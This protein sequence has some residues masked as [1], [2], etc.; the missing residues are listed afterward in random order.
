VIPCEERGLFLGILRI[1]LTLIGYSFLQIS[2]KILGSEPDFFRFF[3]VLLLIVGASF[4]FPYFLSRAKIPEI[5]IEKT[6]GKI[7][8]LSDFTNILRNI[9]HR[10]YFKFLA[11]WTFITGI[12][13][14]FLIPFYS[15][16]LG[17]SSSF[18]VK[19]VSANTLGYGFAAFV[20]GKIVD[21]RGSR[22]VLFISCSLAV[23]HMFFLAHIHL[24]SIQWMK[25]LLIMLSFLGG[26]AFSG[27]LMGDTTRRMTL[28][29]EKNKLSYFAYVQVFGAQIPLVI[30]SPLAGYLIQRN[31]GFHAGIYG[32]YQTVMIIAGLFYLVLLHTIIRMRPLKEKPILELLKDSM[33]EGLMKIRD[34]IASPP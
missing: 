5:K 31:R 13:G 34:I 15:T 20:W 9:D 7:G 3:C 21:G 18:C 11:M 27:Q 10:I 25:S 4:F 30:A 33:T 19:L 29:P 32:I 22:Y 16:E 26:V 12:S 8:L 28:S 6:K 14:P 2:S 24:F 1:S 17:L 23:L